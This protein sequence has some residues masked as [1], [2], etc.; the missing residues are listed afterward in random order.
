[1]T[2]TPRLDP[3]SEMRLVGVSP[4][5]VDVVRRA[6]ERVPFQLF[7]VEGLRTAARQAQLY[8]QGRTAPGKVVTWTLASKHIDGRA[9]DLA[10][11]RNG[12]VDWSDPKDFDAIAR[13][14]FDAA[15]ELAVRIRWGADWDADG[16]PRERGEGD[17]P[18]F[19][20][21]SP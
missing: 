20:L 7:V 4:L 19:E 9:V 12:G 5:L 11:L 10:P 17:S 18:H 3:T 15:S 13:A 21:G 14:M 16:K 6:A 8:A 2:A 1:M